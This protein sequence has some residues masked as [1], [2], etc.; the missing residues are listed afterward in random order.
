MKF[1]EDA[2]T[3]DQLI[4]QI[5]SRPS[6][7]IPMM[8]H[9]SAHTLESVMLVYVHFSTG[10][11][12][13][14]SFT[15]PD[16]VNMP[17]SV[18]T[19]FT[20]PQPIFSTD[21]RTMHLLIGRPIYD[22]KGLQYFNNTELINEA[23]YRTR[24]QSMIYANSNI[25]S[26]PNRSIPLMILIQYLQNI[27]TAVLP[28]CGGIPRGFEFHTNVVI[29]TCAF[30]ERSG[31]HV[32]SELFSKKFDDAP[33]NGLVYTQYN[34]YTKAGRISNRFVSL[35]KSDGS[36]QMFTSRFENGLLVLIDFESF[37]LRL[38]AE[39]IGYKLPDESLHEYFGK[40]YFNVEQLT[41]E[42]YEE[43]KRR[44]FALLYGDKRATPIKFFQL[45]QEY[46]DS[47][48]DEATSVGHITSSTGRVIALDNMF[49]PTP[50][51]LFNYVLQLL[52]TEVGMQAIYNTIPLF[53]HVNSKF[54][55]YTYD[56]ILIDFDMAD[57]SDFIRGLVNTLEG[58]GKYPVRIY[59]GT[60]YNNMKNMT[61]RVKMIR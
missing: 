32:D 44:T 58:G 57:G 29:P 49:E 8:S 2:A 7:M 21:A 45:V 19:Q 40:Q 14:I 55:L 30:M 34:P 50:A 9:D 3:L 61:A 42:Q 18:M 17:L 39:L 4:A 11:D 22:I 38:I 47:L 51:K 12:Y 13:I 36:R 31:I 46:I 48:W 1:V 25:S 43:S 26:Q 33:V 27:A 6:L 41:T 20:T 10:D 37:H 59:T 54:V 35:N 60:N 28:Y 5:Q 52:E 16:A 56:S 24:R 53:T 15:H 23:Q